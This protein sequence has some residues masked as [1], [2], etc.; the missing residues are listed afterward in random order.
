MISPRIAFLDVD[1]TLID[2]GEVI[3]PSTIEAVRTARAN[4]HLVYLSTGRASVEIYAAI[5]D[6]GF[7]GAITAGGGF[8]EIG[9]ELVISRTM[10]EDAVARMVGF[11]EESGYDFYLQSY[12]ELFPSPGVRGRFA[13]YLDDDSERKG[14]TRTDLASVTDADEHPALK[15]FAD[16][17]PLR[18]SGIAKSVFLAADLTAFDRV[19]EALSGD[20]H[21]ITGTIPHMGKGSGEVTLDGVNKGTTLLQLLDKLGID[22]ASAIGIGDST[23]DIEMLQVCGVGIAMGNATDT[24]KAHA[25]E[26]TTSVLDDGVWNAFRRHGLI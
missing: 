11:Y 9:D 12:D 21:V 16:V 24:V 23:N 17:R 13:A 20:F 2:S 6:I 7:D 25:D 1:G 8:A 5:R 4:G 26:V 14:E 15:A 18:Y 19:S 22:A 3:A 10:P